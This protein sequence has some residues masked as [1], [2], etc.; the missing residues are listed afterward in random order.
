MA[1][2]LSVQRQDAWH[3]SPRVDAA[4]VHQSKGRATPA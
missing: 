2:F 1:L 4:V 3:W